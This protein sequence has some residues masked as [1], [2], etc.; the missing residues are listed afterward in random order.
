MGEEDGGYKK[1]IQVKQE[2]KIEAFAQLNIR[3]EGFL[4]LSLDI[5]KRRAK[6]EKNLSDIFNDFYL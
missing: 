1:F 4:M 3:L 2:A 6:Y 5:H